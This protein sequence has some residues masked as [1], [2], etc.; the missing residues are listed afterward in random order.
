[1]NI[2]LIQS[3]IIPDAVDDNLRHYESLLHRIEKR[4]DIIVFPEMFNCGFSPALDKQAERIGEKSTQFLQSVAAKHNAVVVA[5]LPILEENKIYNRLLWIDKEGVV[6]H[7][8]KRHLYFGDEK[9]FCT[10]GTERVVIAKDNI[11]FL[12]A[13]CYDV[14]FP[15]WCRNSY[16][17]ETFLYDCLLII[18]NFPSQRAGT[19]R[20]LAQ[21]RAIENQ[22][23]VIVCNR[24]GKDGNGNTHNGNSMLINP[25]GKVIAEAKQGEEDVLAVDFDFRLLEKI[26][27]RFPIYLDWD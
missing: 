11:N 13:I 12:P 18:A 23:F 25:L 5:S 24:V 6:N 17:E 9:A 1:M 15:N 8:D 4:T 19:L 7:Y 10:A 2:C 26:R 14:R 3:D 16:N 20:L 22:V 21:A 27:V